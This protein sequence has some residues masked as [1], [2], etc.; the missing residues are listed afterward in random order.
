MRLK[1]LIF[2]KK[3][4]LF[5]TAA[6]VPLDFLL[7]FLAGMT[8]YNL[9]F[10]WLIALRPAIFELPL[11][12]Y[13][14]LALGLSVIY[15]LTYALAGLYSVSGARRLRF[16]M[17]KIFVASAAGMALAIVII[18]FRG[19]LFSSRFIVLAAW[20]F[21]LLYTAI[22]RVL[23]RLLQRYAVHWGIGIRRV[24]VI[25]G[26]YRITESLISEFNEHKVMG[27]EVAA[28]FDRFDDEVRKRM[29]ET[30]KA[31]RLDEIIVTGQEIS[32][33]T[34]ADI[35]AFAQSRH[36][37]FKYSADLLATRVSNLE[38]GAIS[39]VPIV[40]VKGTRL[41]GWGRILKR[42]F[43]FLGAIVLIALT[44]PIMIATA[45]AIKLDS[46]GPILFTKLPNGETAKRIGEHGRPFV[47]LK[48]RSMKNDS[49]DQRYKELADK[50]ER[51][52]GPLVKIKDDPRITRV[53]KFIRKYS[54]D[55][56]PQLFLVLIGTM[57]L[58]GPRPHLPEEVA[59]YTDRQRR[60]M[61][62][63]P[64]ITGMAQV[65]GRANLTF[66]DEVRL[67]T[68]YIENW[69]LW[70]DVSILLKTPLAVFLK[71]GAS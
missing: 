31:G 59:K 55:E 37:D 32:R 28:R 46:P 50:N 19:E 22:G 17:A 26:Q 40:E 70:L 14:V 48:F 23:V 49:H 39:G 42:I 4:E 57:S 12:G 24:A 65:S 64:G 67:D 16:E 18:F 66:D 52:D 58:V 20:L 3:S 56:L 33:E 45:I 15:V 36:L 34:L 2:M 29:D 69:T 62:I 54:I 47:F 6:L 61:A 9:R 35:L 41:D 5:F 68:Y 7:V 71:R 51:A 27:Y 44:S 53:G 25:G 38:I 63:K 21:A 30:S 60:V 13:I 10:G 1:A 43:D 11:R 8:A